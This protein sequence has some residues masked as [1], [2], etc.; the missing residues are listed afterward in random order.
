MTAQDVEN[1][2]VVFL[3]IDQIN[4]INAGLPTNSRIFVPNFIS[5]DSFEYSVDIDTGLLTF[6]A[7]DDSPDT[8][9]FLVGVAQSPRAGEGIQNSN[10]DLQ[11]V[12]LNLS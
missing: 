4:T 2:D 9:E 3:D 7:G 6:T 10:V 1:D 11:I 5:D 8:V 12:T